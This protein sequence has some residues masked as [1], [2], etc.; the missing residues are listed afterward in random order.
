VS[1]EV[2][3][4]GTGRRPSGCLATVGV[5]VVLAVLATCVALPFLGLLVLPLKLASRPTPTRLGGYSAA[6]L[7]QLPESQLI[8]PGADVLRTYATE[9]ISG[10]AKPWYAAA[11]LS[12]GTQATRQDVERWYAQQLQARGWASPPPVV[13]PARPG[14]PPVTPIPYVNEWWRGDLVFR[15]AFDR[16]A[17]PG[18]SPVVAY[19]T[20]FSVAI[21]PRR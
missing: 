10:L 19:P 7:Q 11:G 12:A 3:T 13:A 14:A 6:A 4:D 8:Y 21:E 2:G 18:A 17:Q 20:Y 5:L 15:L 16:P 9:Q 1:R